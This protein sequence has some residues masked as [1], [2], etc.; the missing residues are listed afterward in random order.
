[1]KSYILTLIALILSDSIYMGISFSHLKDSQ[2]RLASTNHLHHRQLLKNQ[3]FKLFESKEDLDNPIQLDT[4]TELIA[5]MS[6]SPSVSWKTYGVLAALLLSF[7]SNQWCRQLINYLCNFS[8]S[9]ADMSF[10]YMNIDLHFDKEFYA[11]LASFAFTAVF[12]TMSLIAGTV[13]DT[14]DRKL[15]LSLSC[16]IWSATTFAQSAVTEAWQLIPIRLV[17]GASQA[18]F[19]PA[20]YTILS[21]IFPSNMLASANSVL[22]SGVYVGG[23]L[24]SLSILLDTDYGWRTTSSIVGVVGIILAAFSFLVLPEPRKRPGFTLNAFMPSQAKSVQTESNIISNM[25]SGM[26][27]ASSSLGEVL[28][29][30]DVRVLL[31]ASLLRFAA[32]FTIAIWKAPFVYEKFPGS[33]LIFSSSNALIITAGGLMSSLFGG[34]LADKISSQ[35]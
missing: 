31:F 9:A 1:M 34:V 14:Y 5:D 3:S 24:A 27:T 16:L 6:T 21:D 19:N 30:P 15:I 7:T 4:K 23:G 28:S 10:N 17:L 2:R 26:K 11:A 22:S 8:P 12:A 32:G 13:A 20:A 29:I 25:L 35:R 33:E 18:F